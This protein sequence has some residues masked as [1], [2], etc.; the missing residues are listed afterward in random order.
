M[1]D[2]K[3]TEFKIKLDRDLRQVANESQELLT[4]LTVA[5][6]TASLTA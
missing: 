2:R 5:R 1:A 4:A 6:L 3:F